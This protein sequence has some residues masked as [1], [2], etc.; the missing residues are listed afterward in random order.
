MRHVSLRAALLAVVVALVSR[1]VE[2]QTVWSGVTVEPGCTTL[3]QAQ[4]EGADLIAIKY[5]DTS[6]TDADVGLDQ[7]GSGGINTGGAEIGA[8]TYSILGGNFNQAEAPTDGIVGFVIGVGVI[9]MDSGTPASPNLGNIER[10]DLGSYPGMTGPRVLGTASG[11]DVEWAPVRELGGVSGPCT[12]GGDWERQIIIGY[13][14][15]RLSS[16]A[17]PSPTLDDFVQSGWIGFADVRLLDFFV[18]DP[19]GASGSD[20]EPADGLALINPDG[21]PDTGDEVLIYSD[22]CVE[23]GEEYWYRV[24]PVIRGDVTYF[25]SNGVSAGECQAD[26]IDVNGDGNLDSV[27]IC[28]DDRMDFIDPSCQG[29]GLT[30]DGTIAS[31]VDAG[32]GTAGG[33]SGPCAVVE[34]MVGPF[35]SDDDDDG[36][37]DDDDNCPMTANA[38]QEDGDGDGTGDACDGCPDDAAKA[39]PGLCGCGVSDDDTDGDGTV[40]CNDGCPDDPAK[41]DPGACGCGTPDDDTDGD[42]TADCLDCC[43]DDPDKT[44]PGLCGCDASDVDSDGDGT[45]DCDDGCP[46]DPAKTAP[47]TCGCGVAD[48]D[49]DGDGTADC[50]D[51]C[52]DDASKTEAGACGCGVSDADS[53]GDGTP[54]CFDQCPADPAKI[55]PGACGCGESDADTDGDGVADCNDDCPDDAA[56]TEPGACGCGE[57]DEDADGD[58]LPDC[59]SCASCGSCEFRQLLEQAVP[60]LPTDPDCAGLPIPDAAVSACCPLIQQAV[61]ALGE[62][63]PDTH[64][65]AEACGGLCRSFDFDG[66]A[67]GTV[68]TT[69]FDGL[70]ISGTSPV[71]SFDTG[72]PTCGDD[73][74]ATPGSGPGNDVALGDVLILSEVAS[75]CQ[76]D[77]DVSGGIMTIEYDQPEEL[78]WIG[79]L[80][81]DEPG[82]FVRVYGAGGE[83]LRTV[84]VPAQ[85]NNGWQQVDINRCGVELVEIHLGG[86]GAVTD[87]ACSGRRPDR[88]IFRGGLP[89][90]TNPASGRLAPRR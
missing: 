88:G 53:D 84:M 81:I 24:Q 80:D 76:P 41:T 65:C 89:T 4:A 2:A 43:P 57:S 50:D 68:I 71:M 45:A 38:G 49:S 5:P 30:H 23:N 77:D 25:D 64:P 55:A 32:L 3:W 85:E 60:S 46:D 18:V 86:S 31:S 33:G 16:T 59:L 8:G 13:N 28:Q 56:K 70:T 42:G 54:D 78:Q 58:G 75:D 19:D 1:P 44:D 11:T 39:E 10:Q 14:L 22:A 48:T 63:L 40:D 79:L 47:G 12:F 66:E 74:L 6:P 27:D 9:T 17:F 67:A 61:D 29:L 87:L 72:S 51:A 62:D 73:D 15:Y 26:R 20:L 21:E 83:L 37:P 7:S 52:P 34:C 36:V 90:R 69:Q 82:T 35:G